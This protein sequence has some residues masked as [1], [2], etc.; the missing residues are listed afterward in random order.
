[1]KK[2]KFD[3]NVQNLTYQPDTCLNSGELMDR[4]CVRPTTTN[5]DDVAQHGGHPADTRSCSLGLKSMSLILDIHMM[6]N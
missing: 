3:K 1:M 5:D 2:T 6:F 4:G